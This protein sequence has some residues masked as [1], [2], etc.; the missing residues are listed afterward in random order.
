MNEKNLFPRYTLKVLVT[1]G[2]R[3]E[4]EMLMTPGYL[5]WVPEIQKMREAGG[6]RENGHEK[7]GRRGQQVKCGACCI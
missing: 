7:R 3:Q 2:L 6:G 5:V 1:G 4:D